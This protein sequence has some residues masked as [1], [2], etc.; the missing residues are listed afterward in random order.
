MSIKN[1]S[2]R[3]RTAGSDYDLEVWLCGWLWHLLTQA[4][5]WLGLGSFKRPLTYRLHLLVGTL[6]V[7]LFL[8]DRQRPDAVTVAAGNNVRLQWTWDAATFAAYCAAKAQ[9]AHLSGCARKQAKAVLAM[10]FGL[11]PIVYQ[12]T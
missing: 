7:E 3:A 6:D 5:E 9:I 8:I 1:V 4:C 11:D 10:Q 12:G 2:G